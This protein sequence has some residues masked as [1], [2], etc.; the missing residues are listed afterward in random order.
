MANPQTTL[1]TT[2][3]AAF[4]RL[5]HNTSS[6]AQEAAVEAAYCAGLAT[7][8][9]A[10]CERL[11]ALEAGSV[12]VR[13]AMRAMREVSANCAAKLPAS[14]LALLQRLGLAPLGWYEQRPECPFC[15][16]SSC[17]GSC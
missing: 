3:R 14:D 12:S 15:W 1:A 16:S 8:T 6:T 11:D 9:D 17:A 13:Y 7:L 2:L 5:A 4:G 10:E